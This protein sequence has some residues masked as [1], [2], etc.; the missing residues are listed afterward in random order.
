MSHHF[1]GIQKIE[2]YISTVA[3]VCMQVSTLKKSCEKRL[4]LIETIA[5]RKF[6]ISMRNGFNCLSRSFQR[7]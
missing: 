7:L 4:D 1:Y 6:H 3:T 5:R 2:L